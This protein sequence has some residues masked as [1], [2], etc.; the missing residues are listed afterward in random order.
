[1]TQNA[2]PAN[3]EEWFKQLASNMLEPSSA[4]R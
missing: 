1:M 2:K 3:V 4:F